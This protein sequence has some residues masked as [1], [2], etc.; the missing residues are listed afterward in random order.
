M[1]TTP[2]TISAV[3]HDPAPQ[4][5][6]LFLGVQPLVGFRSREEGAFKAALGEFVMEVN[7]SAQRA[8]SIEQETVPIE[9]DAL[10]SIRSRIGAAESLPFPLKA[11]SSVQNSRLGMRANALSALY[12]H[13]A[14]PPAV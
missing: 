14:Q 3:R 8:V 6:S 5:Q 4:T 10:P 1:N 2:A 7:F 12:H 11:F 9:Y 13:A